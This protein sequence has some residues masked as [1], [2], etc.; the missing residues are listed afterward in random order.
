MQLNE[1]VGPVRSSDLV[2][3]ARAG[4][5]RAETLVRMGADG[6]WVPARKVKGLSR[7]ASPDDAL[8]TLGEL[9]GERFFPH[10]AAG[11][12]VRDR[13]RF[14]RFIVRSRGDDER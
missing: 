14:R 11:D 1:A 6:K 10:A 8:P 4:D 2:Y 7:I 5:I 12:A 9:V 3:L 13:P